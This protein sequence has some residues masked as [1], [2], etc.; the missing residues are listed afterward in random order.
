[1]QISTLKKNKE[2]IK[3]LTKE[4][5]VNIYSNKWLA[6][7]GMY[8]KTVYFTLCDILEDV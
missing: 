2:K 3:R 4:D 7:E 5:H 6:N 1:M 8:I